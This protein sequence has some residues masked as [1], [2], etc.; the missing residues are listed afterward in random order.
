MN[1]SVFNRIKIK[2]SPYSIIGRALFYNNNYSIS[3]T[4]FNTIAITVFSVIISSMNILTATKEVKTEKSLMLYDS[5]GM[6]PAVV[7][8]ARVEKT[9]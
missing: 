3:F 4:I 5:N 9:L 8:G 6:V 2:E 7:Y 1:Y